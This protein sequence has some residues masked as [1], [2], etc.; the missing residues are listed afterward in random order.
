MRFWWLL[1]LVPVFA[2]YKAAGLLKKVFG[3]VRGR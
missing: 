3:M 2:A 1:L